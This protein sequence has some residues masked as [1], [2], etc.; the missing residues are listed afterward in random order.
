MMFW[1]GYRRHV[2]EAGLCH[3]IFV[4]RVSCQHCQETQ[5]LLSGFVLA[6]RLNVVETIGTVVN[7]VLEEPGGVR[8]A[9][10]RVD[11]PHTTA[12]GWV[13]RFS[14]RAVKIAVSFA[15]LCVELGGEVITPCVDS[16]DCVVVARS[17]IW[18][19]DAG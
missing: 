5:A 8:P 13:R 18:T 1:A 2:R 3:Q 7:D 12:R 16:S 6:G 11:V 9:A 14:A 17:S 15:A 10:R 4:P 19:A